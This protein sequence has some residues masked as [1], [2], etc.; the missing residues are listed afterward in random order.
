MTEDFNGDISDGHI[1][2]EEITSAA[3]PTTE[4]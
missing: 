4:P 1:A 3:L 2:R